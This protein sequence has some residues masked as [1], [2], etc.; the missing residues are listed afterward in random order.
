[1]TWDFFAAP[2]AIPK[3]LFMWEGGIRV[4]LPPAKKSIWGNDDTEEPFSPAA[5]IIS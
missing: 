5:S 3:S 1:M 2:L 4:S